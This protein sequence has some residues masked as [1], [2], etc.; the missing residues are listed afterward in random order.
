[1]NRIEKIVTI[2]EASEICSVTRATIWRWI[3]SG[4]LKAAK[5]AGGHH[6]IGEK[7][8]YEFMNKEKMH[9]QH[10]NE[11]YKKILVVDDDDLIRKYFNRLLKADDL[12]LGFASD[13]FE[14]GIKTAMFKP[15]LII[16]DLIMPGMDGFSVCRQIKENNE[17]SKIKI[18]AI[19]GHDTE[20]NKGRI[21][22]SGADAFYPKPI[23][24][25]LFIAEIEKLIKIKIKR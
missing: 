16:L 12:T 19:S 14:A 1:M 22:A 10:R 17:T 23:D 2:S 25:S 4:K 7:T 15:H 24:T 3:K 8:L 13:G 9:S 18:L 5:T 21:L 20:E 6:R 11:K